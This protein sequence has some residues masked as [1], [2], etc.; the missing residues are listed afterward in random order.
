MRGK[1]VYR[2]TPAT[3]GLLVAPPSRWGI[4][5]DNSCF[6]APRQ[7]AGTLL[8]FPHFWEEASGRKTTQGLGPILVVP[9]PQ[10]RGKGLLPRPQFH[11]LWDLGNVTSFL[12][13]L[14]WQPLSHY[15]LSFLSPRYIGGHWREFLL[16]SFPGVRTGNAPCSNSI[17]MCTSQTTWAV[18]LT[19]R[20]LRVSLPCS[21][22]E[23][24]SQ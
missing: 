18:G 3:P 20:L 21:I 24:E 5:V 23:N 12:L 14:C 2:V 15:V 22:L 10:V 16:L 6:L 1:R 9:K 19:K 17:H 13:G 7:E 11:L 4:S 8:A